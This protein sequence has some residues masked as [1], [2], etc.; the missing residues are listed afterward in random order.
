MNVLSRSLLCVLVLSATA[1]AQ[2]SGLDTRV[3]WTKS[4]V[5]GSPEP[6]AP[7]ALRIAY[8]QV[9]FE[10]PIAGVRVPGAKQLMILEYSGKVWLIDE[11]RQTS[12][13]RLVIDM[14]MK[15]VGLALHP[16]YAYP[17]VLHLYTKG[18]YV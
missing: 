8:P 2:T 14:E 3:E 4:N 10:N 12:Q 11:N 16:Q 9:Q 18:M 5:K 1:N 7:Y 17:V 13:K 15:T 6:P